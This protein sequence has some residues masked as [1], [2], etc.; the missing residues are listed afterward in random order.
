MTPAK[1]AK[2]WQ[3]QLNLADRDVKE[4]HDQ[5]SKI[6]Q[7]YR[8]ARDTIY[9]TKRSG[10][11]FAILYSNT[12]TLKSALYAKTP[13]PD[14]RRRF[15]DRNPV[16]RTAA[17][18]IE[19]ALS[20]CSDNTHHDRAY[21]AGVQ[22]MVLPGR[23]VVWLTY[24]ADTQ[25]V[26]QIDPMT[27]QPAIGPD[28]QPV[29]APQ[30]V[31][32]KVEEHHVYWKDFRCEPARCWRDV[33]W[34]GR[35]HRMS[36]EDLEANGFENAAEVPLNWSADITDKEERKT[37][38]ELSRAEV[39]EIWCKRTKKR[40]WIVK[41]YGKALR[42]DDDPYELTGFFPCPE[43][44]SATLGTDTYIPS[45][46]YAQYEDQADDLDE[47]TGRISHLV[48]ALR[49]R[50]VYDASI[51]ELRR[52]S[53]ASDNEFIPVD[54][55]KYTTLATSGGLKQAFQTEDLKPL[56][57]VLLGLYDQ[58]D[59]LVAAI[60]EVSG[61]SDIVRGSSNP[62]ETATAQN[63]KAQFGSMRLKDAQRTVQTWV[64][65]A[66]RIKAELICQNFQPQILA[67]MTGMNVQDQ[68]FQ[69]AIQILRS[70]EMRGYQVDIETDST[71]FEDAES[72]KQSRT[73]LLTAMGGFAQQWLPLVQAAPEMMGLVG[74]LMA[75]GVRGFKAGRSME[76][77]IDET[78][79]GIQARMQQ[80][81]QQ[82]PPPDPA[83]AKAEGEMALKQKAF[84]QDAMLKERELQMKE[85][86]IERAHELKQLEFR[87]SF[88]LEQFK[89]QSQASLAEMQ[90]QSQ[91]ELKEREFAHG[92]QIEEKRLQQSARKDEMAMA[93]KSAPAEPKP[94]A[95]GDRMGAI[96]EAMQ[97]NADASAQKNDAVLD[98]FGRAIETMVRQ[99]D[100]L[101]KSNASL[102]KALKSPRR[103]VRDESNRILGMQV[104]D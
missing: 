34:V 98:V 3:T 99:T 21:R 83:I 88:D 61:I 80:Q 20:Y 33:T 67:Q 6:E 5:G 77:K 11:R 75:F 81:A 102:V 62:N 66:Y 54:G 101:V 43:P 90:M 22:D 103:V 74:E 76:D 86:E 18:I 56:A 85:R 24:E 30:V 57:D 2:H 17:D 4:W 42:I 46:F 82:P 13:K 15:G 27:Q 48:K 40:Y 25:D 12:E 100:E 31:D 69:Q 47:I 68:N 14:A 96:I 16:A 84:E 28:G 38:D 8:N 59:R 29:L 87:H 1:A 60:Y 71:V 104:D 65:D 36:R 93:A 70:D 53:R 32:Q 95:A 72:E 39:W 49:R 50:G 89:A 52:L 97:A 37:E 7:R 23:G 45:P 63:I 94:D 78:M 26:P 92:T 55:A 73:E 51:T 44:I 58:R 91:S 41:G 79:Q 19:R 35:R 10:K 9:K 64:R